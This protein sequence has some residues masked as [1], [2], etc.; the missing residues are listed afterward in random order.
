[1]KP[2]TCRTASVEEA[3]KDGPY[4]TYK[5]SPMAKGEFQHNLWGI[6][7]E[8]LSGRW[9]WINLRKNVKKFGVRN[10]PIGSAHA[11]SINLSNSWKQ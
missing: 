1:M 10:S 8:E 2:S 5:G 11:H 7:D 4:K 6:K 3:E 9:D